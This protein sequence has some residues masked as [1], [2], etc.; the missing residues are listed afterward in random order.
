M[1]KLGE[2]YGS[3]RKDLKYSRVIEINMKKKS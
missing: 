1:Q 2:K 3:Q